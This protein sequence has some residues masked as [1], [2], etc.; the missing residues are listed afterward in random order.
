[1][2][3]LAFFV[4][5]MPLV[6]NAGLISGF[7]Q[8]LDGWE[9]IGDVS[10]QTADI[11][12]D[13]TQ[14]RHMA[15]VTTMCDPLN[16]PSQDVCDLEG[17]RELP[18]SGV[19]SPP[20]RFADEFL[21]GPGLFYT[22]ESGALK[23]R[24]YAPRAGVLSFDWNYVGEPGD[25]AYFH[26]WSEESESVL[27]ALLY[28]GLG[29][30]YLDR[31]PTEVELCSRYF[32]ADPDRDACAELGY[33]FYGETGWRTRTVE[34]SESGWYWI[35]FGMGEIA[36]GTVP[37]L[38][39]LDNVRYK[40]PEPG[41]L[42]LLCIGLVGIGLFR[43]REL[44]ELACRA[45]TNWNT[46]FAPYLLGSAVAYVRGTRVVTIVGNVPLNQLLAEVQPD[47]PAVGELCRPLD[48][49]Q[50]G[51]SLGRRTVCIRADSCVGPLTASSWDRSEYRVR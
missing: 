32:F 13:P 48:E 5:A 49:A 11:G 23:T 25:D 24:F 6:A 22:G 37:S 17:H 20:S 46:P 15:F 40:V 18:Y 3:R 27:F 4:L 36:E 21:N 33:P 31:M 45:I 29:D 16:P 38:L 34:V 30:D 9:Y 14:A 1:M 8:G 26:V 28:D 42:V 44:A 7:E 51:A 50:F 19:S 47:D 12:I 39:A 35:G 10:T 41:T 2:K 43:R